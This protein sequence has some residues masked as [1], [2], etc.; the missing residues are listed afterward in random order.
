M[1]QQAAAA[2]VEEAKERKANRVKDQLFEVL[3]RQAAEY[4]QVDDRVVDEF[5]LKQH[6]NEYVVQIL[7]DLE[8]HEKQVRWQLKVHRSDDRNDSDYLNI[9]RIAY[10]STADLR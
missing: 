10:T 2:N 4:G 9:Y 6:G 8:H 5:T 1:A 7:R 3:A